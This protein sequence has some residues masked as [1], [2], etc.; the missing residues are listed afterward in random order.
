MNIYEVENPIYQDYKDIQNQYDET[1]VVITNTN[2]GKHG[3][4]IGG[5]VRFYGDDR[6]GII[7]KWGELS[8]SKY[9]EEYGSCVF[10]TLMKDYGVHIHG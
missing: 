2:W 5:I 9:E 3:H 6:I 8:R 10:K 7:N 1:L 4:L